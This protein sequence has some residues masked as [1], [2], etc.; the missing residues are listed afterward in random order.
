VLYAYAFYGIVALAR[1]LLGKSEGQE[2]EAYFIGVKGLAV[3]DLSGLL[4]IRAGSMMNIYPDP[5]H[6]ASLLSAVGRDLLGSGLER[7]GQ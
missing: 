2:P 4:G 3:D 6:L 7:L 5:C 1:R